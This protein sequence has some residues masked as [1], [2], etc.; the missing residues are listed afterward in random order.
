MSYLG[1]SRSIRERN[2]ILNV[3][4]VQIEGKR[5]F[6]KP[7][8]NKICMDIDDFLLKGSIAKKKARQGYIE[9]LM[10]E[11][12]QK[13]FPEFCSR[14]GYYGGNKL[15]A[16][17]SKFN[18]IGEALWKLF[19]KSK[20]TNYYKSIRN[21]RKSLREKI[22]YTSKH[23]I[24]HPLPIENLG[25][26]ITFIAPGKY[27]T[28]NENL[29][30]RKNEE[31]VSYLMDVNEVLLRG[32]VNQ[33]EF[34]SYTLEC[35][36]GGVHGIKVDDIIDL[37]RV[38][39]EFL[40]RVKKKITRNLIVKEKVQFAN[41]IFGNSNKYIQKFGDLKQNLSRSGLKFMLDN[42]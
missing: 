26:S 16:Y 37:I 42:I 12:A 11:I 10:I 31:K 24:P 19:Q 18:S 38:N 30:S 21:Y 9:G 7:A 8:A 28:G 35:L 40:Y 4:I 25:F 1:L 22:G 29:M 23:Y 39:S 36:L 14:E 2:S 3:N 32:D 13:D 34:L 5:G 15:L 20:R 27:G 6:A 33:D 17:S 41:C